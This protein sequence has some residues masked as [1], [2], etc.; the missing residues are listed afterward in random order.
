MEQ[1]AHGRGR[2]NIPGSVQKACRDITLGFGSESGGGKLMMIISEASN[3]IGS[4]IVIITSDI[5]SGSSLRI[6]DQFVLSQILSHN[7][8]S[9]RKRCLMNSYEVK[10]KRQIRCKETQYS[11]TH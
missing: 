8:S 5:F 4:M 9:L 6:K 2:I 7:S 10:N 3:F 1:A 11:M